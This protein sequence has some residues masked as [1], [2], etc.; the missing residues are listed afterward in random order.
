MQFD[1]RDPSELPEDETSCVE[2]YD[3]LVSGETHTLV[4]TD[5]D[6]TV[7]LSY[8]FA[9]RERTPA[10]VTFTEVSAGFTRIIA[11]LDEAFDIH[12]PAGEIEPENF[13][14]IDAIL[15]MVHRYQ[16]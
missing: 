16:K 3:D 5:W 14:T 12:I 8:S 4:F 2:E 1:D 13:D 15:E 10:S 11:A 6:G 9:A 7:L